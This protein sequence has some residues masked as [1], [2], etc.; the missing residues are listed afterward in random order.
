MNG[1]ASFGTACGGVGLLLVGWQMYGTWSPDRTEQAIYVMGGVVA[2]IG[3]AVVWQLFRL[4]REQR[5]KQDAQWG[6]PA[7]GRTT[8]G[9]G[10]PIYEQQA[11][12]MPAPIVVQHGSGRG[13]RT[14]VIY[15][16]PPPQYGAQPGWVPPV[17]VMQPQGYGYA[18]APSANYGPNG[19]G[20]SHGFPGYPQP[21]QGRDEGAWHDASGGGVF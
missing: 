18:Q 9:Y 2:V 7:G 5:A 16:A 11:P 8:D 10:R 19:F 14:E 4:A 17:Q 20:G 12:N 21:P 6:A 13:A 1:M 15:A 3:L